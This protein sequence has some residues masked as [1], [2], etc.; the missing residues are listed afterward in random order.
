MTTIT[1]KSQLDTLS[2][3]TFRRANIRF[4]LMISKL[5]AAKQDRP[6]RLLQVSKRAYADLKELGVDE[7]CLNMGHF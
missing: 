5:E 7:A 6:E 3:S 2:Y 4:E 1:S